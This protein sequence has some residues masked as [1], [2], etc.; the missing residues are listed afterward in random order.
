MEFIRHALVSWNLLSIANKNHSKLFY[1]VIY[2]AIEVTVLEPS[3]LPSLAVNTAPYSTNQANTQTNSP[4]YCTLRAPT[5]VQTNLLPGGSQHSNQGDKPIGSVGNGIVKENC[6]KK[7]S[8]IDGA[9]THTLKS[10][11]ANA[12]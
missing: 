4:R 1:L 6:G 5:C 9:K 7:F 11:T 10:C 3:S 12:Q 8:N 2:S